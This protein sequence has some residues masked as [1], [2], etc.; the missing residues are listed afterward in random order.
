MCAV[1]SS[2]GRWPA[3]TGRGLGSLTPT[4]LRAVLVIVLT[5][6]TGATDAIGFIGLGG[7]FTS[8]MTGN[9]VLIGVAAGRADALLALH[10]GVAFLA[11]IAGGFLGAR[12]AGKAGDEAEAWPR[13]VTTTLLVELGVVVAFGVGWE[14][15][16]GK[17]PNGVTSLLL[18]LN[19]IALGIQSSAVL[20]FGVSGLSTTYLTGTLTTVCTSIARR[21][22]F[23]AYRRSVAVLAALVLGA[24]IGAL[25]VVHAARWAPLAQ[26]LPLG[27]VVGVAA[28]VF[29]H[30]TSAEALTP[31][32]SE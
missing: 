10:T 18:A 14:L 31:A 19:A 16:G 27:A 21:E 11:Y 1:Q 13:A 23:G 15:A 24:C 7:V 12:L 22:P 30:P 9:M 25:V 3:G 26:L 29:W 6:V 32:I 20:R 5:L 28:L 4:Q 8:V 2:S 17:P